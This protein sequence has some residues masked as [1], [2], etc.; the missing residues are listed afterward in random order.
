MRSRIRQCWAILAVL[1]AALA[2]VRPVHAL[3][4]LRAVAATVTR[5]V[6][7]AVS[8]NSDGKK[9]TVFV[10]GEYHT[11]RLGQLQIAVMLLRLHDS[12]GLRVVV[13]VSDRVWNTA[14]LVPL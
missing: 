2:V 8:A 3:D 9:G 4:D 12:Q 13:R 5:D 7:K 6:G 10:F 11:S 14:R 1:A